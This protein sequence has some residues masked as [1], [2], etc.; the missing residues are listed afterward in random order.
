MRKIIPYLYL[1]FG[2]I[3]LVDGFTSFFKDKETYRILF[4]WYTENKYIFL[5]IKIVIA[6]AFLSFGY[7]RYK[8]SKI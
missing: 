8:Q 3:I 7:K 4:N 6:F 5:L 1:I 2:I